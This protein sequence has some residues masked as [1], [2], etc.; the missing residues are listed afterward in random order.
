MVKVSFI[1]TTHRLEED[2]SL[3][4]EIRDHRPSCTRGLA[5]W[6]PA[7]KITGSQI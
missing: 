6:N 5:S 7:L 1:M 2:E 3:F 4:S